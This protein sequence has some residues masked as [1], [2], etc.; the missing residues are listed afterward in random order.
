MEYWTCAISYN[1]K[2]KSQQVLGLLIC[3]S[4]KA[5]QQGSSVTVWLWTPSLHPKWDSP[6]GIK[7]TI[8]NQWQNRAIFG[9]LLQCNAIFPVHQKSHSAI[10][11]PTESNYGAPKSREILMFV[12]LQKDTKQCCNATNLNRIHCDGELETIGHWPAQWVQW[13]LVISQHCLTSF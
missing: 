11:K 4:F 6:W 9:F 3:C 12:C 8:C 7:P 5:P 13:S 10:T 2:T 1:P